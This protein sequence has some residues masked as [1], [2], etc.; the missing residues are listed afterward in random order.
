[1]A[2]LEVVGVVL[3]AF[4]LLISAL[5][6]YEEVGRRYGFWRRI[7]PEYRKCTHDLKYHSDVFQMNLRQLL[8][9]QIA[10]DHLI[11]RMIANPGGEEWKMP[12]MADLLRAKLQKSYSVYLE[13]MDQFQETMDELRQELAVES[14]TIQSKMNGTDPQTEPHSTQTLLIER[15][16]NSLSKAN[17]DYQV[18]RLKFSNGEGTRKRLLDDLKEQNDRLEKLLRNSDTEA[19]IISQRSSQIPSLADEGSLCEFWRK[20]TALFRAVSGSITCSCINAHKASILLQHSRHEQS[21]ESDVHFLLLTKTQ[22]SWGCCMARIELARESVIQPEAQMSRLDEGRD[23]DRKRKS[24]MHWQSEENTSLKSAL[25]IRY[26]SKLEKEASFSKATTSVSFG[27]TITLTN[28]PIMNL[29]KYLREHETK[30]GYIID[31]NYRYQIHPGES[32]TLPSNYVVTL[33]QVI[34][35]QTQS[36]PLPFSRRQRYALALLLASSFVQLAE[37]PWLSS[38]W[39]EDEVFFV[40][41]TDQDYRLQI[42]QPRVCRGLEQPKPEPP[43]SSPSSPDDLRDSLSRLA[44]TLLQLCFGSTLDAQSYRR[45]WPEG[46]TKKEKAA[47][48]RLAALEWLNDVNEEAGQDYAKAISWCLVG[49]QTLPGDRSSWRREMVRSVIRPLDAC[50][51]YLLGQ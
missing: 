21:R 31:D 15:I 18:Y 20:A 35:G 40:R 39:S 36:S 8:L 12:E 11:E 38:H 33:H 27:G 41:N 14:G 29:C 30:P 45:E 19:R 13:I 47:Y 25:K 50:H 42:D 26:I 51:R 4:P 22:E 49:S 23:S 46:E 2:G 44:I 1:M 16:K 32:L 37:S 28:K 9:P 17:R 43:P 5:E 24:P 6:K 48:D 10:D 7:R 3:G 34:R